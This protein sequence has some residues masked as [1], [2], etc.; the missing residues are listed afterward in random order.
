MNLSLLSI[1]LSTLALTCD[2]SYITTSYNFSY[3]HVSLFNVF[4]DK[5][6]KLYDDC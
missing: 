6:S 5:F 4:V 1:T 2:I 3:Q